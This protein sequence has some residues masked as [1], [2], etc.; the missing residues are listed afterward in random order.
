[1]RQ[2]IIKSFLA[3]VVAFA[4]VNGFCM[5]YLRCPYWLDRTA[6]ATSGVWRPETYV[7]K[8]NEGFG[9]HKVDKNGYVNDDLPL[10]GGTY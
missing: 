5:A 10:R 7:L 6:N 3:F 2:K 4:I 9:I 8:G 1:M